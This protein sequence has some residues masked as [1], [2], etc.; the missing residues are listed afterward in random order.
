MRIILLGTAA[1]GGF[2]QWNCNCPNCREARSGSNRVLPRTQ[3]SAAV[4]A[5]GK[6]WFLLNA[7][8]DLRFQLDNCPDLHPLTN[9]PRSTRIEAVL[10][11]NA[12]LDHTLGLLLMRE[13]E[14]IRIHATRDVRRALTSGISI[15]PTLESFCGTQ[16][17]RPPNKLSPLI[18]RDGNPSGLLYQAIELTGKKPPRYMKGRDS[19]GSAYNVGYRLVDDRTGGK[20]VFLPDVALLNEATLR[21]ASECD[22]LLFDGTFWSENEMREKGVGNLPASKTGHVPISGRHGSLKSL[23]Q[24]PVP[25]RIYTHINNTNPILR[26]DSPECTA[27]RAAGIEIGRDGTEIVI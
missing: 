13:G 1:G 11:T 12:D 10:L 17:V 5:N 25:R 7:S 19:A 15:R 8:P 26:E 2:P 9:V 21:E 14:R 23:A 3:S 22:V 20:M 27:V 16:W 24:L 18:C 6:D 4:S